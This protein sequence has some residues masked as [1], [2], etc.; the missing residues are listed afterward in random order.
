LAQ[1]DEGTCY[2]G[3]AFYRDREKNMRTSMAHVFTHTGQG[4]VLRGNKIPWPDNSKRSPHLPTAKDACDLLAAAIKLYKDHMKVMPRRVVV[5]KTSKF[6]PEERDGFS[7]AAEGIELLDLVAIH[8]RHIK[9]F[10]HGEKAPLRGTMMQLGPGNFI[11]YTKGYTPFLR[12]YPGPRVP[13]PLEVL[14]HHGD[15]TPEMLAREILALSKMN[16]NSA[17]FSGREP[18][19][20]RFADKVGEILSEM[21]DEMEP[22]DD[23]R[24]YM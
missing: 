15:A 2:V 3:V 24:Y 7:Q 22:P 12:C 16:Y 1:L 8:R 14:E 17:D 23:F 13:D 21:P 6:W 19:T 18:I 5:H 9:L 4:L 10:R 11:L 20:L